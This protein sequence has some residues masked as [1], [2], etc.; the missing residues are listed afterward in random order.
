MPPLPAIGN[1]IFK[2]LIKG[3]IVGALLGVLNIFFKGG[4]FPKPTGKAV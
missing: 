4:P 3:T 1:L 2:S